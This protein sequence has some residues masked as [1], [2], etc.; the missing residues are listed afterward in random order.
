MILSTPL[1][2]VACIACIFLLSSALPSPARATATGIAETGQNAQTGKTDTTPVPL[3]DKKAESQYRLGMQ[4]YYG[5][6]VST[7]HTKGLEL[8]TLSANNNN[9][10]AQYE[11][12]RIK[13]KE[14]KLFSQDKEALQWLGKAAQNGHVEALYQMG[15]E[16][17]FNL[18]DKNRIKNSIIWIR[19]AAE[20][21]HPQAQNAMGDA[22]EAGIEGE[23]NIPEALRWYEK[24]AAQGNGA[25]FG[26]LARFYENG[27]GVPQNTGKAFEL[28]KKALEK[29]DA[30]TQY[31]FAGYYREGIKVEKNEARAFE[32]YEKSARQ[33]YAPAIKEL[34]SIYESGLLGQ[35][36]DSEKAKMWEDIHKKIAR[37]IPEEPQ[38]NL[39]DRLINLSRHI[40]P[41]SIIYYVI[42]LLAGLYFHRKNK[43]KQGL[44]AYD[45]GKYQ[46]AYAILSSKY[47][48]KN[49]D[50]QTTL[51]QMYLYGHVVEQDY[52]KA[53]EHFTRA[54]SERYTAQFYIGLMFDDGLGVERDGKQAFCWY[55]KAA[56]NGSPE[57]QNNLG[58]LY[59]T[60]KGVRQNMEKA[61][62]W[63]EKSA[64][65][66]CETAKA[67][68]ACLIHQGAGIPKDEI[69]A[70][71]ITSAVAETGNLAARYNLALYWRHVN[72]AHADEQKTLQMIK[73]CAND[74]YRPAIEDLIT[75]Y[76][77]GELGEPV[78]ETLARHWK[79]R[80][81][82]PQALT[83]VKALIYQIGQKQTQTQKT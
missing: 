10:D 32:L 44:A 4:Y 59:H 38:P 17:L 29:N 82:Q 1:H 52:K 11:L 9:R 53:M 5:K 67:N 75:V 68:L 3:V 83:E 36:P 71:T 20:A 73:D 25:A 60:G 37:I 6:G 18:E 41:G 63:L 72:P 12:Y 19:K 23:K 66:D 43:I 55:I 35:A 56:E 14:Q 64:D 49:P 69:R 58:V 65:A 2:R 28:Y 27:T 39:W 13:S 21:G 31:V 80:L 47:A 15:A 62:R 33:M 16:S 42:A 54:A 26:N 79:D 74:G 7:N 24:S 45:T 50:A 81:D 76:E 57:A 77:K 70:F 40:S 22:C 51:G 8:L 30:G 48:G 61:Y 34:T 78:N 46:T